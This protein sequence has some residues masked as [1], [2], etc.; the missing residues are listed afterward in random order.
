M[1]E[2]VANPETGAM[3]ME[4]AVASL[5][6]EP[7]EANEEE[8]ETEAPQ[9]AHEEAEPEEVEAEEPDTEEAEPEEAEDEE[10]VFTVKIDGK[11]IEVP[12]SELVS[13]YQKDADYRKKTAA[14]AE[15]RRALEAKEAEINTLR[16]QYEAELAK[17]ATGKDEEPNWAQLAEDLDPWEYQKQRAQWEDEQKKVRAAR[18]K[19]Q[20][21]RLREAQQ[22][23]AKE[24]QVLLEKVPEWQDKKSFESAAKEMM[25]LGTKH[26]GFKQEEIASTIDHR[27]I[28]LL[29]DA[30]AYRKMKATTANPAEKRAAKKTTVLKPGSKQTKAEKTAA[31]TDA[32]RQKLKRSGSVDDA[33]A[34]LMSG[35]S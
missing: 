4:S 29:R 16:E 32:L 12:Q 23:T 11:E 17:V 18:E 9:E 10:P 30:V 22:L 33:V 25:D 6:P 8:Q 3:T 15:E 13:G 24:Q 1:S 34:L 26:Y 21:E 14:L 27:L 28:L 19:L 20:Q 31:S 2:E 35:G 7:R 5:L